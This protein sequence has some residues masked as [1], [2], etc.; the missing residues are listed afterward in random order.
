MEIIS[1]MI[2]IPS[3]KKAKRIN[4]QVINFSTLSGFVLYDLKIEKILITERRLI[5][6]PI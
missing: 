1:T 2:L 4:A 5:L 3:M 6:F